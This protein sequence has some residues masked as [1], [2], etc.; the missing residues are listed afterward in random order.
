MTMQ[1]SVE[2]D[3]TL[4]ENATALRGALDVLRLRASPGEFSARLSALGRRLDADGRVEVA[5]HRSASSAKARSPP[6][7]GR[8]DRHRARPQPRDP[9]ARRGVVCARRRVA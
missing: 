6:R 9:R 2:L 7:P 1:A 8:R 3:L 5:F 4:P